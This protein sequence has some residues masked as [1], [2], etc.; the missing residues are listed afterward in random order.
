M[1]QFCTYCLCLH[2]SLPLPILSTL[3]LFPSHMDLH[4]VSTDKGVSHATYGVLTDKR[5]SHA[6]YGVLTDKRVSHA[7]YDVLTDKRVSHATFVVVSS[8][9]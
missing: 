6:T 9:K 5:L 2:C 3:F 4:D 7:T 1:E 8:V